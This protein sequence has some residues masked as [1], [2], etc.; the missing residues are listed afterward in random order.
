MKKIIKTHRKA[1]AAKVHTAV[2]PEAVATPVAPPSMAEP[3]T[4]DVPAIPAT[5]PAVPALPGI[6]ATPASP[7]APTPVEAAPDPWKG[8][9]NEAI[10]LVMNKT[11]PKSKITIGQ[12]AK[13]LLQ[14]MHEKELI[15]AAETGERLYLP[16]KMVSTALQ[17]EG[18]HFRVY[19]NFMASQAN[20]E[21]VQARSYQFLVD[22]QAKTVRTEDAS[23]QQDLLSQPA[24]LTFKHNPMATDID[25]ILGGVDT[26]NKHKMQLMIVKKNRRN[27]QERTKMEAALE[28][29]QTKIKRA[30]IYFR[31]TYAEK[32]L[33]NIANAYQ[34]SELLKG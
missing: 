5:V 18:S 10:T 27:R 22:L 32:A 16:D 21:R 14:Q 23:T 4:P 17:E 7:P 15:H 12:Q 2:K 29:A 20:G 33:Q 8:K 1:N 34:F 31:R 24:E 6:A 25:S 11:L 26:F 3:T 30:V 9:Q 28:A 19:L 13:A